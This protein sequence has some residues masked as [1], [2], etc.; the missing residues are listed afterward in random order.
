MDRSTIWYAPPHYAQTAAASQFFVPAAG[1]REDMEP[2]MIHRAATSDYLL[3]HFHTMSDL[4]IDG[5]LT[6]CPPNTF[7]IWRPNIEHQ[8]GNR[9]TKWRHSWIHVD[10]ALAGKIIEYSELSPETP[11]QLAN[12]ALTDW[13]LEALLG[14][15][16]MQEQP[17][18]VILTSHFSIWMTQLR[19]VLSESERPVS[20]FKRLQAALSYIQDNI[21]NSVALPALA[22]TADLSVGHFTAEFKSYFGKSPIDY[23]LDFR[24]NRASYLLQDLQLSVSE[25]AART[26]FNDPFYFSKQFKKKYRVSPTQFRRTLG[27]ET[28][29]NRHSS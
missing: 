21:A 10:G 3:M 13:N 1:I 28:R 15:L 22:A 24:L 26:G 27:G 4:I 9:H 25:I 8:Y 14:E 19:R 2:R 5:Q 29:I 12:C 11:V 6:E 20:R 16:K 23:V 7:I 18:P 17:D